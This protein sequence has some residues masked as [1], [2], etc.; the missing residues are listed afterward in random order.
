MIDRC[1]NKNNIKYPK[2]GGRGIIVCERW[3]TFEN[4]LVD[5]GE[6]PEGKTLDRINNDGIY[7]PSNVRWATPK[8][9]ANNRSNNI[10]ITHNGKTLTASEWAARLGSKNR[11]LVSL[12]L[13][14]GWSEEKAV[15]TPSQRKEK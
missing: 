6:K 5:M 11:C 2:Y 12:R 8:Q 3:R 4:F 7:E 13:R 14:Q 15:T 9:Q 10:K 1:T